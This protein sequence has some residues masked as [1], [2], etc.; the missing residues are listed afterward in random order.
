MEQATCLDQS[1]ETTVMCEQKRRLYSINQLF[2]NYLI[3]AASRSYAM[4]PSREY[5]TS[6]GNDIS[7]WV[8]NT[9]VIIVANNDETDCCKQK[10]NSVTG[11]S[12]N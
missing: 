3:D 12:S 1:E 7:S 6:F 9:F 5:P 8:D 10:E 2:N 4:P 11:T